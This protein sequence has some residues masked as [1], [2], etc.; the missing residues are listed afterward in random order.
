MPICSTASHI[1]LKMEAAWSS[2]MLV[3]YQNTTWHQNP[4][5]DLNLHCHENLT[6]LN[7]ALISSLKSLFLLSA[8]SQAS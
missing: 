3:S 4:D 1:T 7:M 5:L 8:N 2:K 6:S